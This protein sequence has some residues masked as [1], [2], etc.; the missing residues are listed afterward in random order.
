MSNRTAMFYQLFLIYF[1]F[2]LISPFFLP[3]GRLYPQALA[4]NYRKK[5]KI[6]YGILRYD[7]CRRLCQP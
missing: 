7:S 2:F 4:Q 5:R 3:S 1:R 6:W